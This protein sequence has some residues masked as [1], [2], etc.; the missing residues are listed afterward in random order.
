MRVRT[1]LSVLVGLLIATAATAGAQQPTGE[2]FGKVTDQSGAVL[3]GV[4]VT[5]SAPSLLQ[6]LT[7]VTSATGTYQFPRLDI[8]TYTAA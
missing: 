5:L 8:G 3:P 6:P 7:A 2:I 1:I 4:S